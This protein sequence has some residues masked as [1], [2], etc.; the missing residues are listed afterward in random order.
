MTI[1]I[2][3]SQLKS[4]ASQFRGSSLSLNQAT[5]RLKRSAGSLVW[6]GKSFQR[7]TDMLHPSEQKLSRLVN[8]MENYARSLE[9][10]AQA[11]YQADLE[12][13]RQ[14]RERQDRERKAKQR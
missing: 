10:L 9:T 5:G 3:V 14:D 1:R 7:F 6:E 2:D 12:Q 13:E 8:D 4:I 11:L